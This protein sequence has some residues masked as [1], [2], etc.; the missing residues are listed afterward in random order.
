M[1]MS[2]HKYESPSG[3]PTFWNHII[4][5]LDFK[6]DHLQLPKVTNAHV[7]TLLKNKQPIKR[8]VCSNCEAHLGH[9][10]AD[11]PAPFGKRIQINS[12]S[13]EFLAKPWNTAPKYTFEE[14]VEIKRKEIKQKLAMNDYQRLLDEEKMLGIVSYRDKKRSTSAT[15]SAGAEFSLKGALGNLSAHDFK[16]TVASS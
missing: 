1:F 13:L 2:E 12:A 5:S 14:R 11:G 4:D 8:C 15:K 7:D 10:F 16:K 9:V 3:Y 6:D